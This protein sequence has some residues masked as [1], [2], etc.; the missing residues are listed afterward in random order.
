MDPMRLAAGIVTIAV[1]KMLGAL[2]VVSVERGYDPREFVLIA[3]GGAGPMHAGELCRRLGIG[4]A[5]IPPTPGV[6]SAVG[7]LVA[8]VTCV[9]G[10]T[11]IQPMARVDLAEANATLAALAAEA[12][13]RL[14]EEG[15]PPARREIRFAAD[16]RYAGQA[17]ELTVVTA[18]ALTSA[19]MAETV[20]AFHGEH[21]RLFGFDWNAQV[22]VE[23]VGL[24][25]M[26]IGRVEKPE[27]LAWSVAGGRDARDARTGHRTVWFDGEAVE[28]SCYD[29]LRLA[30]GG[31]VVGPAI[32]EQ[33]DCT[34]V[35]CPGQVAT[36][37]RFL[38]LVVCEA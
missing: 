20:D 35:I 2:R 32:I 9:V 5:V 34:T 29:R 16:L 27:L 1:E 21:R 10:R 4:T 25:A 8:D 7:A 22:P 17:S 6:L 38:N 30:P 31:Q 33:V 36:V 13:S 12:D 11:Q 37:D 24:K 14:A 26:G 19:R 15:I 28:T 18:D 3:F 23:L